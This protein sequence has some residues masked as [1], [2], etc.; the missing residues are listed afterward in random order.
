[1][2]NRPFQML[3]GCPTELTRP[4]GPSI[5]VLYSS[6]LHKSGKN[7]RLVMSLLKRGHKKLK[8]ALSMYV[9]PSSA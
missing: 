2:Q 7:L 5:I 1:M 4:Q 6:V 9:Q 8:V 3:L